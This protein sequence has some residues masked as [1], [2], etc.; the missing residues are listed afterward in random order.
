MTESPNIPPE[1]AG[2]AAT[3]RGRRV[4]ESAKAARAELAEA[5]E[6][7][8]AGRRAERVGAVLALFG[9]ETPEQAER[10][11]AT[12]LDP[13]RAGWRRFLLEELKARRTDRWPP[14]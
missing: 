12:L 11:M 1:N 3:C 10:L 6:H 8:K 9:I 2:E 7:K 14:A 4:A 13:K 5:R